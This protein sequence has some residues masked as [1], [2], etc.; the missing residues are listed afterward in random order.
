MHSRSALE[1][2]PSFGLSRTDH[3]PAQR[4]DPRVHKDVERVRDEVTRYSIRRQCTGEQLVAP[5]LGRAIEQGGVDVPA[6][7]RK[8]HVMYADGICD[9]C[10]H[11][12]VAIRVQAISDRYGQLPVVDAC[13]VL[14]EVLHRVAARECDQVGY[15]PT[16]DVNDA[17]D[18]SPGHFHRDGGL[19]LDTVDPRI[20]L[21]VHGTRL[22]VAVSLDVRR[23][24]CAAPLDGATSS[25]DASRAC[26]SAKSHESTP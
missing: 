11:D 5:I 20:W 16:I 4:V 26:L 15:L 18:R 3:R 13:A 23:L 12:F 9:D 19:R 17:Q 21:A 22:V 14:S 8:K 6:T 7:R 2:V 25:S 24:S 10:E 1:G